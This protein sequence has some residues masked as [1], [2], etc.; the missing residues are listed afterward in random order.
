MDLS[1]LF[2]ALFKQCAIFEIL[3][4]SAVFP[5]SKQV[6]FKNEHYGLSDSG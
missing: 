6:L 5:F 2:S 3:F 1:E 4:Y